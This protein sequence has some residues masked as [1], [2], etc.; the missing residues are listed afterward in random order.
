MHK[1][2]LEDIKGEQ[3]KISFHVV[4]IHTGEVAQCNRSPSQPKRLGNYLQFQTSTT[5]ISNK[6][7]PLFF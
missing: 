5:V 3:T 1:M 2:F 7:E 4:S 6:T